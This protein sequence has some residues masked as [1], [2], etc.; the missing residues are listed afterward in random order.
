MHL[1]LQKANVVKFSKILQLK[2]FIAYMPISSISGMDLTDV[3]LIFDPYLT[4]FNNIK[5]PKLEE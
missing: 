2:A 1:H 3:K 5:S 4:D